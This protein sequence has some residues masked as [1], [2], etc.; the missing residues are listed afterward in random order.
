MNTNPSVNYSRIG[1]LLTNLGTPD[2]PSPKAV[3]RFLAEFLS[4][5]RVIEIS[6]T[7]WLPFLHGLVLNTRPFISA[8]AYQKI[9]TPEGSPLLVISRKQQ[10]ALHQALD[11]RLNESVLVA[12][13]MRYGTPSIAEA[14]DDL[15]NANVH[16]ILILPLYPQYSSATTGSTFD[17]VVDVLK[18]WRWVPELR[19]IGQYAENEDYTSALAA[20][21]EVHW[22]QEEPGQKLLFSFHGLPERTIAL[23]DPY[24]DLCHR[25]AQRVAEKLQI[26]PDYWQV[27]FQSRFGRTAWLQPYC[28]PTLIELAQQGYKYVDIICPGFAADCLETLEEINIRYRQ[29]FLQAGGEKFHYIPALNDSPN[30]IHALTNLIM[31]NLEGWVE[32]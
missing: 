22:G 11:K 2:A 10:H 15:K 25:T 24:Y 1:I 5:S 28:E 21:I 31:K 26:P 29:R 12:L 6:R 27:V 20:S 3:R 23:G 18:T 32:V 8:A 7:F 9:W 14:L 17:A 19:M 13:G 4:D 16:R 30:H